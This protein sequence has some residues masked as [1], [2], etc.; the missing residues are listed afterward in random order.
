MNENL[1]LYRRCS[2]PPQE[3]LKT[4]GAGRL[5]GYA[6]IN[7]MWRI[8]KLTEEFGPCGVGWKYTIDRQWTEPG[9]NNEL[10]AFCNISLFVKIDGGW[11][12]AIPGTGGASFVAKERNG[13]YTSDECY[14]MALTDALSV[15]CKALGFG[16]DV[17][18]SAGRTKNS[19]DDQAPDQG[20]ELVCEQCG[21]QIRQMYGKGGQVIQPEQVAGIGRAKFGRQLCGACQVRMVGRD[22]DESGDQAASGRG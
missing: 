13:M 16:A 10:S 3:A 20:R 11:S 6:G 2:L 5:K 21:R 22:P 19:Q 8:M 4:I 1:S 12:E 14:K 15:A 18:W 17:Y 7:P 9:A